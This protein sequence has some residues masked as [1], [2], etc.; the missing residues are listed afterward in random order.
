MSFNAI[1][2]FEKVA[3][4]LI[5]IGHT[6]TEQHFFRIRS[7]STLDELLNNLPS[8]NFPALMVHDTIDGVIGDFSTSNNYADEP[9]FIFYILQ[10]AEFGDDASIDAAIQQSRDIG[11][12]IIA[13]M[14]QHSNLGMYDLEFIDFS[15]IPYQSIGP[16]GDHCFGMMY[17]FNV[18]NHLELL[19]DL[20][21]W[22]GNW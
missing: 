17:M 14:L 19:T 10:R 12:K 7:L 5:A 4:K 9:Q 18:M 16:L 6:D 3:R 22:D 15:R 20:E 21:D 2:Y 8:A 13:K 11:T 1:T